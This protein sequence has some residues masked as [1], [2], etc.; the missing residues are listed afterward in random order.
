MIKVSA[1]EARARL[2]SLLDRAA[3]V[4]EMLITRRGKP[5]ASLV[6][7]RDAS[8]E[9]RREAIRRLKQFV[10]GQTLGDLTVRELRE[11]GRRF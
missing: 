6:P 7:L 10:K 4:E 2:A 11:Q 1:S 8:R 5:V 9:R 3:K